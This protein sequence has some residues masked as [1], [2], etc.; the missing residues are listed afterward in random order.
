MIDLLRSS[1]NFELPSTLIADRPVQDRHSSRLLVYDQNTNQIT[2]S[3]FSE[4]DRFLPPE[5]TLV[6]NRSKVFPARL[7]GHKKSGGEAEVFI[8]SLLAQNN[9]YSCFVRA[10]GKRKE[11]DEFHFGELIATIKSING[12]GTFQVSFNK[13]HVDLIL[14]LEQK[15]SIPIPP[16]IRGGESDEQ[17]KKNYQTVFA[18]EMGS[19][20]APTA[21]LHFSE[22]LLEKLKDHK[23]HLASVTL[24]VGAG[25]FSPIK[26]DNI[27]EHKMHEEFYSIDAEN[28]AII[29]SAKFRVAVGTTTLR[30][31]ESAWHEGRVEFDQ[32]EKMKGTSI[33]LH[34]GK[35]V[36]SIDALITNFHLPES[37]LLMLVSSLIGREKALEL[38]QIAI[39][40]KYRF[41]SYGDG[42]LI[43]RDKSYL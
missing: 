39:E 13:T 35:K 24:H 6:F 11:G 23:H 1:Y 32:H 40:Q 5:S 2:H 4:L 27:L 37:S 38:Y 22:S 31:L 10:S 19:V 20:A 21:G 41:F 28:L 30:T 29:N 15:G 17:D 16:Y 3:H 43:L 8:L 7:F 42:M 14:F 9:S 26:V 34:P 25:T 18:K 12:D 33:F 36:H